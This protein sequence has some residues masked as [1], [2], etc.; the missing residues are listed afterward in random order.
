MKFAFVATILIGAGGWFLYD[1]LVGFPHHNERL[2]AFQSLGQNPDAWIE[3][4]RSQHWDE[5]IPDPKPYRT[6]H[7]YSQ[8]CLM[9]LCWLGATWLIALVVMR[10]RW[11]LGYDDEAVIGPRGQRIGFESILNIDKT[12]WDK[13]GLA[14]IEYEQEGRKG[15][16]R[17]DDYVFEGGHQ[18]LDQIERRTGLGDSLGD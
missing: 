9:T 12:Q 15:R 13:T 14:I 11:P 7:F 3:H 6:G 2:E 8:W 17:I 10:H 18:V 16:I 4:A 5:S 1:G